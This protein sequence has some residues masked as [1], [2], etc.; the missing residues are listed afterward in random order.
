MR[1]GDAP[2]RGLLNDRVKENFWPKKYFVYKFFFRQF[3][4]QPLPQEVSIPLQ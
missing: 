3:K 1:F 2:A 4:E